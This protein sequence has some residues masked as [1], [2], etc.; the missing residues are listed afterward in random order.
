MPGRSRTCTMIATAGRDWVARL[1]AGFTA[2]LREAPVERALRMLLLT[3]VVLVASPLRFWLI[4]NDDAEYTWMFAYNFGAAQGLAFGR[5]LVGPHGP[6]GFLTFP[7]NIGHNLPIALLF[8]A[9]AWALLASV[10]VDLFFRTGIPLARLALF[11]L[12]VGLASP[13]FWFNRNSDAVFLAG[14][15][16]L[17]V[18]VRFDHPSAAHGLN[19]R[20]A[21]AN[22][23]RYLT[24]LV[25]TGIMPLIKLS[26][27]IHA[28]LALG[29]FL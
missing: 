11:S 5:D 2:Q 15:L 22:L 28:A 20:L 21:G 24:A 6:L 10:Y 14:V 19:D 12:C 25:L 27:G 8:Q 13:L 7:Q 26:A 29:G 3:Y 9:C 1:Q 16:T 4:R 17:L 23:R 18:M